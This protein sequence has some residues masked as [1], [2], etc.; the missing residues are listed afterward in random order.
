MSPS[1]APAF[2]SKC[3]KVADERMIK[4]IFYGV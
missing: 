2:P 4:R 3:D 1:L